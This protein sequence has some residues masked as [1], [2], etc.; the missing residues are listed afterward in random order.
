M[1]AGRCA[2]MSHAAMSSARVMGTGAVMGQAVGA[3][4]AIAI[5][6]G[7][8]SREVGQRRAD[9]LQQSLLRQDCYLPWVKQRFSDLTQRA[10]LTASSGDPEPLRDGTNRPV[11]ADQHCWEGRIGDHVQYAW[12]SPVNLSALTL[13]FDSALS[14]NIQMSYHQ[15]DDQLTRIPEE[16]VKDFRVE[17]KTAD[18]WRPLANV[19]GN[20]Q[21]L[22]RMGLGVPASAVRVLFGST[23]GAAKVRL[24]AFYVE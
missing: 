5:R 4:A 9:E 13:I 11:G 12:P 10:A 17:V 18:G 15:K 20:Y 24:Y 19:T 8:S 14:R 7:L 21:R 16:M 6:D 3:A 22:F 2:S 1:F 23:W